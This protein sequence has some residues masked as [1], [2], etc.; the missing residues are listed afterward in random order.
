MLIYALIGS[1]RQLMVGPDAATA[2]MVAAAITRW[3]RAIR[4]A[5]WT[6]R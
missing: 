3:R 6:C 5:W 2:A 1:S 4:S